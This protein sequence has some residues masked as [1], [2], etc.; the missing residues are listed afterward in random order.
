MQ[1]AYMHIN[2]YHKYKFYIGKHQVLQYKKN[3]AETGILSA[4]YICDSQTKL[5]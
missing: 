4:I 1:R 3:V 2:P 5:H